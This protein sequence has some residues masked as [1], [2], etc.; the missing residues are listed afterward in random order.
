VFYVWLDEVFADSGPIGWRA[1]YV[2]D[3]H[4]CG[5]GDSVGDL[6]I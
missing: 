1:N 6:C 2:Q 5:R 4:I 3:G